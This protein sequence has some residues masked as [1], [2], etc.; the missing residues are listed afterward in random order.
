MRRPGYTLIEIIVV[1]AV[2]GIL[3]AVVLPPALRWRDAAAVRS[4]R[5]ELAAGL[6]WTRMAAASHGGAALVLDP[7]GGRFWTRAGARA[8]APV[9]LTD[10][11]GVRVDPGSEEP[12][13]L[14]Y[15][16]LGIGRITSR[17]VRVL[18]G[19]AEAGL[20]VSAYGRYRRW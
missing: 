3:L 7:V 18:R 11:Y 16:G 6:A 1:T 2:L 12:V 14:Y 5:D 15:D 10:R 13:V 17:T 4:A 8:S 19:E 9:S 20:T